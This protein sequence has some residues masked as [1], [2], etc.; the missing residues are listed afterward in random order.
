MGKK[1]KKIAYVSSIHSQA[2]IDQIKRIAS[3]DTL[4]LI[5][6]NGGL[7][8]LSIYNELKKINCDGLYIEVTARNKNRDL[9]ATTMIS[10]GYSGFDGIIISSGRFNKKENM[11]KPVY[12]LDPS[13]ML[14]LAMQLKSE[15]KIGKTFAIGVQSPIGSE[16]AQARARY[17]LDNGA[18]FIAIEG[19]DVIEEFK[20]RTAI[21]SKMEISS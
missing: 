2:D 13:Q 16:A 15:N 19:D 17:F 10:A 9:I 3:N 11:A 8:P 14:N 4:L 20:D 21:L 6:E 7:S 1:L 12:D 5:G 18:D